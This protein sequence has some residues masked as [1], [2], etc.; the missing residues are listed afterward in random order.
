MRWLT[1]IMHDLRFSWQSVLLSVYDLSD[2][3]CVYLVLENADLTAVSYSLSRH[4][5]GENF[6]FVKMTWRKGHL[7]KTI[8]YSRIQEFVCTNLI[9]RSIKF[10][11]E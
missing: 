2:F 5:Q 10:F 8:Y 4:G 1:V 9:F 11:Q 3:F 6:F 7:Y